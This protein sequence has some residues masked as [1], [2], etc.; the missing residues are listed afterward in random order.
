VLRAEFDH[1]LR[2]AQV[3]HDAAF[4]RLWCDASP[5]LSRYLRVAGVADPRESARQV[6]AG[7]ICDLSSFSGDEIAWRA[8]MLGLARDVVDKDEAPRGRGARTHRPSR[9]GGHRGGGDDRSAVT[10]LEPAETRG[11]NDTIAAIRDLPLGQGEILMLR[12][13]GEL[14]VATVADLVGTDVVAVRRS[15]DRAV[16]RLGAERELL[17]WSL[18]APALPEELADQRIALTTFRGRSV[19][20]PLAGSTRVLAVLPGPN[21]GLRT[22]GKPITRN[23]NAG[24]PTAGKPPTV[25]RSRMAMLCIAAISASAMSAGALSAAAYVGVLPQGL[26]QVMHNVIG[27]PAATVPTH[28]GAS[29]SGQ[30]SSGPVAPATAPTTG[31]GGA[32]PQATPRHK[33]AGAPPSRD[34][35]THRTPGA[36]TSSG[37]S[38]AAKTPATKTPAAKTPATKTPATKTP[39]AKTPAAK[40]P[41]AK[42][43]PSRAPAR[44]PKTT[45]SAW[46]TPPAAKPTAGATS[47]AN[48]Q[49]SSAHPATPAVSQRVSPTPPDTGGQATAAGA[50]S[51]PRP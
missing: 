45:G 14:P 16:E 11:V 3:G 7:V 34:T 19:S 50:T 10:A 17:A 33:G 51:P 47:P 25:V 5:M 31:T 41:T 29:P 36:E 13:L 42:P 24:R 18:A 6:W 23:P 4:A 30:P 35:A 44:T 1:T 39:A 46:T 40:T 38:Q 2:E 9:V 49:A 26:Q 20:S 15:E 37:K 48:G 27:A 8:W 43:T 28:S 22:T 12:L 32:L 21:P